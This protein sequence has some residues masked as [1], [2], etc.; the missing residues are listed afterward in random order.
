MIWIDGE[1]FWIEDEYCNITSNHSRALQ[2][3]MYSKAIRFIEENFIRG[4][5]TMGKSRIYNP[6]AKTFKSF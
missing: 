6:N 5:I 4:A 2:F 1:R 3:N